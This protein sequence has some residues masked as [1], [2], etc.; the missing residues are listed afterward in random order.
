[1]RWLD[2]I[3]DVVGPGGC[4]LILVVYFIAAIWL[5]GTLPE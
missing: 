2:D 4:A 5:L 3:G 1:M